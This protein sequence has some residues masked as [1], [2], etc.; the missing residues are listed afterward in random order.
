[1][2]DHKLFILN[3]LLIA[4]LIG[5]VVLLHQG[6]DLGLIPVV[7]APQNQVAVTAQTASAA[8]SVPQLSLP[9]RAVLQ[10]EGSATAPAAAVAAPK[11]ATTTAPSVRRRRDVD[12]ND[13][14]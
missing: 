12:F 10:V 8:T 4:G 3:A 6:D 9:P 5:G 14:E 7:P 13:G 11:K 2:A 1:M